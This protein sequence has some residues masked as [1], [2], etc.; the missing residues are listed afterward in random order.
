MHT[1]I[2][3]SPVGFLLLEADAAALTRIEFLGPVATAV[4]PATPLLQEVARQLA[5]WFADPRF[6]FDL[7]L[8]PVGT[9]HRHKV[10]AQIAAIGLGQTITY[11]DI[12]RAIGSAPRAVGGACG[13]NPL[14]II[15]PCHRV[16]AANGLGGFN[17]K[18]DGVDWL[19]VKRWLLDHER[20]YR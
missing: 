10:W 20:P 9:A 4:A 2:I 15:V 7:P 3:P 11:A 1:A 8:R 12:A 16:V 13:A 17:A 6:V 14:P 19:P 18:K 5:A